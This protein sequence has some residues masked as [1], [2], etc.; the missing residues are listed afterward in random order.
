MRILG[1]I[2]AR[3]GSK[4]IR[5]KNL[6]DLGGR[7]LIAWTINSAKESE[8]LD[9]I[10][11][12][13]SPE[14][15]KVAKD[16]GAQVPFLRPDRLSGDEILSI[17]VVLHALE[18]IKEKY[19]AVLLLQPTSPFRSS[20]DINDAIEMFNE[21]TNVISVVD[22]GGNH[23]ARMKF[24][25]DDLLIDPPFGEEVENMPRQKL[26]PVYI[27][28]GAIYLTNLVDL[29]NRTFK[30]SRCRALIMPKVRS[31]NIDSE[32]DLTIARAMLSQGLV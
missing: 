24:I 3:G 7:P 31:L 29:K 19:Q 15:A 21:T 11:S 14:I 23:P 16:F 18:N 10:V 1:L 5:N 27:R 30:G 6:I 9:V 8:L 4:S 32:F 13:D 12:T 17:D 20:T 2:P 28:N 26:Q 22:V 25:K